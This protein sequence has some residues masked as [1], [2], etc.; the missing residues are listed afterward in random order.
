MRK[1]I[2]LFFAIMMILSVG[3]VSASDTL[4]GHY[5][6]IIIIEASQSNESIQDS[7]K[8]SILPASAS[9]SIAQA[10][11]N[12]VDFQ[13]QSNLIVLLYHSFKSEE[14]LPSPLEDSLYTTAEK[15]EQDLLA[16]LNAGYLPISL[17]QYY[18]GLCDKNQ[19]YFAI[20]FDDGYRN[21]YEIAYP[22]ITKYNAY[23]DIFVIAK[24]IGKKGYFSYEQAK[25]MEESNHIRLYSHSTTHPDMTTLTYGQ[26][27]SE[28]S[29]AMNDLISNMPQPRYHFFA[30]PYGNY[31]PH[32]YAIG[33]KQGIAL[34]LV[35]NKSF[36]ADHLLIRTP[37]CYSTDMTVLIKEAVHN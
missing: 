32:T 18:N 2:M 9:I 6:S 3:F 12:R 17:E 22:I 28:F 26:V 29:I 4:V 30:Y 27:V 5:L 33:E 19:K 35:Q 37:V 21:N 11:P 36:T 34:Q 13:L 31:N 15:F 10:L 24:D 16:L 8:T 1:K 25:E 14:T 23:S 20:T 7:L